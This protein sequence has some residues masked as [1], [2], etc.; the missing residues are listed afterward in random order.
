MP[1]AKGDI[2][3][4]A[5]IRA[6][7]DKNPKTKI[8][9]VMETLAQRGIKVSYNL[10]YGIKARKGAKRRKMKRQQAVASAKA[11][12]VVNPVEL[13]LEVRSLAGKAGGIRK[14]KELVDALAE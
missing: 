5:E 11:A 2:N 12:G 14:F 10:V 4:S 1:R 13:I 6:I 9:E 3:K 8:K 7:L